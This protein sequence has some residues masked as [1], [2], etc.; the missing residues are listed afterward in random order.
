[1]GRAGWREKPVPAPAAAIAV[2]LHCWVLT[3]KIQTSCFE[4]TCLFS[5]LQREEIRERVQDH[6]S[7]PR[8]GP[9]QNPGVV[10][11]NLSVDT[12]TGGLLCSWEE[13]T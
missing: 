1:M 7:F 10:F 12:E 9:F 4:E 13:P 6:A 3:E 11:L 5:L 2:S 8:G